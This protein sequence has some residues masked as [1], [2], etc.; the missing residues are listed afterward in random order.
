MSLYPEDLNLSDHYD[1]NIET[2]LDV[3]RREW[4]E[5]LKP[6]PPRILQ[7]LRMFKKEGAQKAPEAA[8][9]KGCDCKDCAL[10]KEL[11]AGTAASPDPAQHAEEKAAD[12]ETEK[13]DAEPQTTTDAQQ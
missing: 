6:E 5:V 12:V 1:G 7:E 10:A 13:Q 4:P 3:I 11:R 2:V 8:T 9:E